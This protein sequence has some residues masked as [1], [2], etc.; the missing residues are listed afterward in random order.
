M[1]RIF[2][3]VLV[4]FSIQ[5][6][7]Q[8]TIRMMQYNLLGYNDYSSYCTVL[9]NAMADKD[10]DLKTIIKYVKPDIFTVNEMGANATNPQH[11]MDTAMNVDGV[12]YYKRADYTN[13]SSS[14]I[15]NMLYYNSVKLS[16]HSQSVLVTGIRDINMYR[17]YYN[18][19]DLSITHDTAFLYCIVAHLKAGSTNADKTTRALQTSHIMSKIDSMHLSANF[20]VMGDFNVQASSEV[21]FQNLVG[22]P[23]TSLRF[24]DPVN[25]L[26][27][28]N[29]NSSF[30]AYH[31]QS[32]S[33]AGDGCKASS[34]LDDRFDFIL[35]AGNILYGADKVQ[36]IQGSYHALAQ[37]G[38]HYNQSVDSPA[39]N[40]VPPNVLT[41]LADM[42][43]HLPVIMDLKVDQTLGVTNIKNDNIQNI[44][45]NN[46]VT[47]FID[48]SIRIKQPTR[49]DLQLFSMIGQ[50]EFQTKLNASNEY[51]QCQIPFS[52]LA[53][54]LY[55]LVITDNSGKRYVNKI[56][57]Q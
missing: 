12:T 1:K 9:N 49:L 25:K 10:G 22:Y 27:N 24:H 55:I 23:D 19:S 20:M 44:V 39:N 53:N 56:I 18:A 50:C 6:S 21:C 16:L 8:D 5:L 40:S 13:L 35:V 30:A 42:S 17:L 32:T 51:T 48:L 14:N 52:Q 37:D 34:G 45:F 43:D 47:D 11:L 26:G 29:N 54:G 33:L 57:K 31:T 15:V 41:A 38:N 28:W 3:C 7:A 36:Y 46:P 4:F 2:F